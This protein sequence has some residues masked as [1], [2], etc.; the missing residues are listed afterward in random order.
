MVRYKIHVSRN[1]RCLGI[2]IHSVCASDPVSGYS[3]MYRDSWDA[4]SRS[5]VSI[6][7]EL[8]E[9]EKR[10]VD[11]GDAEAWTIDHV[12]FTARVC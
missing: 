4:S 6:S 3:S 1:I 8:D 10:E 9:Y 12:Y 5:S 7:L 2:R 11:G